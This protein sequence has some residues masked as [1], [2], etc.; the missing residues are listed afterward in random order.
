MRIHGRML[1]YAFCP[2]TVTPTRFS[3]LLRTYAIMF[4]AEGS[5]N[6]ERKRY[7]LVSDQP[8][9]GP[10]NMHISI[11]TT[12]ARRISIATSG[13]NPARVIMVCIV[14]NRFLIVT[15]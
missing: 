6:C 4:F 13:R 14:V 9:V 8:D 7:S 5:W 11:T 10:I 12:V 3:H 2:N 1:S 15:L